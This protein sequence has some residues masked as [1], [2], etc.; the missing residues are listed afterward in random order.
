M[1]HMDGAWIGWTGALVSVVSA[2]G[3]VAATVVTVLEGRAARRNTGSLA[4]RD[5]WWQRWSWVA[6]RA[7]SSEPSGRESAALMVHALVTREWVTED[8]WWVLRELEQRERT[9]EP[10]PGEE[11]DDDL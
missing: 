6:E 7:C 4:H 10:R 11:D 1:A 9:R 5:L 2:C 8:D 3:A